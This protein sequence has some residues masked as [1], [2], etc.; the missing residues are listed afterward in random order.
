VPPKIVG[1]EDK[2]K[3]IARYLLSYRKGHAVPFISVYGR[4][5]SG[6]STV[7]KFICENL[8]GDIS[9]LVV[10]LRKAKTI[11]GCANL[12]L[13]ELGEPNLECPRN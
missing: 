9:N 3:E 8:G 4:S 2:A 10:N 11:F 6:K 13:S 5:G 12:V 1:R 7:V